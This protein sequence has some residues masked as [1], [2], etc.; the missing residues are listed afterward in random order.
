M[1]SISKRN[2]LYI[3]DFLYEERNLRKEEIESMLLNGSWPEISEKGVNQCISYTSML[4]FIT[5]KD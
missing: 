2:Q 1:G 3:L 4:K 5:V